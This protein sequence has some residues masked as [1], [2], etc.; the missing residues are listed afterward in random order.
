MMSVK[1]MPESTIFP[2]CRAESPSVAALLQDRSYE[3][4][5]PPIGIQG[6]QRGYQNQND[7]F[8]FAGNDVFL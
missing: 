7:G 2:H 5:T 4:G 6:R 8:L 1:L 3:T